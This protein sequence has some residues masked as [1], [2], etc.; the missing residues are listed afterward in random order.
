MCGRIPYSA[1]PLSLMGGRLKEELDSYLSHCSIDYIMYT[2]NSCLHIVAEEWISLIARAIC[3]IFLIGE[4]ET[5]SAGNG[6]DIKKFTAS[7][8]TKPFVDTK[9]TLMSES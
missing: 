8:T 9:K 6:D 4:C 2:Y 3:S 1:S 7:V 5:R